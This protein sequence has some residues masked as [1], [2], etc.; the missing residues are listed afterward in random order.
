MTNVDEDRKT[1]DI[2]DDDEFNL[3]LDQ[4]RDSEC[5]FLG[6]RNPAILCVLRITGKRREEVAALEHKDVW[7]NRGLLQMNFMLLKKHRRKKL[8]DGTYED[9][10]PPTAIKRVS[11]EDPLTHDILEYIYYVKELDQKPRH[12][13]PSVRNVF[14]NYVIEF[15]KGITGRTIYDVVRDSADKAGIVAWPHLFRETAGAEEVIK[16]PSLYGVYKVANRINVTER[17]AWNYMR[18]HAMNVIKRPYKE[19]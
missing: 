12:F 18:R 4:A 1:R 13:W 15:D 19:Q 2:L 6:Y 8:P 16:D 7:V 10:P 11:I 9:L 5:D 3:M 14:G 17:T